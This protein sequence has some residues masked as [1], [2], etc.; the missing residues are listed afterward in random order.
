MWQRWKAIAKNSDRHDAFAFLYWTNG[1]DDGIGSQRARRSILL[2]HL[3]FLLLLTIAN[4]LVTEKMKMFGLLCWHFIICYQKLKPGFT[5]QIRSLPS[6]TIAFIWLYKKH[7]IN[8][9][10]SSLGKSFILN[11][12]FYLFVSDFLCDWLRPIHD[13]VFRGSVFIANEMKSF[14]SPLKLLSTTKW[15][16]KFSF[17][18]KY[19]FFPLIYVSIMF[20]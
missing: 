8:R 12:N 2:H 19:G 4:E 16:I 5:V 6:L 14:I 3:W 9:L 7:L 13:H 10:L 11:I 15:F 1:N 17:S 20:H 18:A